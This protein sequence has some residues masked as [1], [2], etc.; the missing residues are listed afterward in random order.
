MTSKRFANQKVDRETIKLVVQEDENDNR[1]DRYGGVSGSFVLEGE[2]LKLKDKP[3]PELVILAFHPAASMTTTP[4]PMALALTG[5]HVCV[6]GFRYPNDSVLLVERL[7]LDLSYYIRYLRESLLYQRVA[8][9]GFCGGGALAALYQ[10]Q[11]ESPSLSATPS[12]IPIDLS[13]LL[14]ADILLLVAAHLGR[15]VVLTDSLDPT[16]PFATRPSHPNSDLTPSSSTPASSSPVLS[17]YGPS[18]PQPPYSAEFLETYRAAQRERSRRIT[19]WARSQPPHS[20]LVL[21]GTL[22]D[23]RWMDLRISP[24]QRKVAGHC[25]MG[26]CEQS[27]DSPTG[28]ARFTTAGSWLSQ[29]AE[30]PSQL[31]ARKHLP[32]TSVPTLVV[33]CGADDAVPIEHGQQLYDLVPHSAKAFVTIDG[34]EHY[35]IAKTSPPSLQHSQVRHCVA[36]IT[37][38]INAHSAIDLSTL[39]RDHGA[40][41]WPPSQSPSPQTVDP[42]AARLPAARKATGFNHVALVCSDMAATIRFYSGVLGFKL[43]KTI[44]LP[45]GGQHFFLDCGD[46]GGGTLAF[47]WWPSPAPRAP[48]VATASMSDFENGDL[49]RSAPGS[50]NHIAFSYPEEGLR[51]LCRRLR[52]AGYWVSPLIFHADNEEGFA[53]SRDDPSVIL[54]SIYTWGPDGEMVEFSAATDRMY[55]DQIEARVLH[56]PCHALPVARL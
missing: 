54:V 55:P 19:E 1:R 40:L 41:N 18:A 23:P 17:L 5:Y 44:S 24:N 31:D 11:A 4:L 9:L 39:R 42:M 38:F 49:P 10:S 6:A 51:T 45:G 53:G 36:A 48:G 56:T 21:Q 52:Q 43:V 12:G 26:D 3:R 29:W 7:L 20:P 32:R 46:L 33:A 37:S 16:I 22:A 13:R 34:A 2:L 50:L 14:R 28:W 8:L 15:P 47:F 27:N 30:G 35:F 25:F